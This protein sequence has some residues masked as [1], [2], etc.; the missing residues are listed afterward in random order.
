MVV[1]AMHRHLKEAV[2]VA[3]LPKKMNFK[4]LYILSIF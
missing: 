3:V 4:K 2:V 1:E